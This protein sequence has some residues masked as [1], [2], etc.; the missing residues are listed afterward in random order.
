MN[1]T[2]AATPSAATPELAA[3]LAAKL[4]DRLA[5]AADPEWY[6]A[7]F[8]AALA[9]TGGDAETALEAADRALAANPTP[10]ADTTD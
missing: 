7:L 6:L 8:H 2:D 5:A 3:K 1:N 9:E 4:A 10:P